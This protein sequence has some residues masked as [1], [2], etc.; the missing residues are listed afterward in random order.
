MPTELNA[1]WRESQALGRVWDVTECCGWSGVWTR[2]GMSNVFDSVLE[3]PG[4]GRL[5]MVNTV[6]KN[7][8]SI[9]VERIRSSEGH[10]LLRLP[11]DPRRVDGV[12]YLLQRQE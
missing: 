12:R 3:H 1:Q 2:R 10:P 8:N 11:G 5:T 6:T 4:R 7:G 9:T